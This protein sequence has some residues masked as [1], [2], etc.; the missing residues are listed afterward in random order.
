MSARFSP[1]N[2]GYTLVELMIAMTLGLIVVAGIITVFT[3]LQQVYGTALSQARVQ[4]AGNAISAIISPA[5]RGAGFGGCGRLIPTSLNIASTQQAVVNNYGLAVQGYDYNGTAGTGTYAITADDAAND[6]NVSDWAPA[7]DAS[8][9]PSVIPE[10]GSDV[11]VVS[12]EMPG[13][14]PAGVNGITAGA[15]AFTVTDNQLSNVVATLNGEGLPAP[16]ALSD[17]GKAV[18]FMATAVTGSG[19]GVVITHETPANISATFQP[20]FAPGVQFVPLQQAVFYVAKSAGGQSALYKAIYVGGAWVATPIVPGVENMQVMYGV[21]DPTTGTIQ[22]LPASAV[23]AANNWPN[24]TAVRMA[25]LIE[26]GL[27]S[28]RFASQA[29]FDVLGTMVAV[30]A[31][32]RLRHVY[33]LTVNLRNVSL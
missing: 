26:G 6:A 28:N 15:D 13:T 27:G 8:F 33:R 3:A 22:W 30:P 18:V 19:A 7:L 21:T 24:V 4:N 31:D 23:A 29:A 2:G 9:V 16:A 11:L 17:C 32:T 20:D 12:G 10:P 14:A 1:R 5:I 25:F